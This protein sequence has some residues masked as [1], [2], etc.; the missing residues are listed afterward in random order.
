M[1]QFNHAEKCASAAFEVRQKISFLRS[2]V[3]GTSHPVQ[4]MLSVMKK[5]SGARF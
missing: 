2:K 3:R 1:F 5:V 4:A